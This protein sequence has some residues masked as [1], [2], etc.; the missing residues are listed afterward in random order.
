MYIEKIQA[1]MLGSLQLVAPTYDIQVHHD[2]GVG[3]SVSYRPTPEDWWNSFMVPV[4]RCN[5]DSPDPAIRMWVF[6]KIIPEKWEFLNQRERTAL[7]VQMLTER[8]NEPERYSLPR[9][10]R[11]GRAAI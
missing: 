5:K 4:S 2:D 8:L 3:I 11:S 7:A 10:R 1:G 6:M 9:A